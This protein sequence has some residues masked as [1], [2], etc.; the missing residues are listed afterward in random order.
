MF[1]IEVKNKA[2]GKVSTGGNTEIYI[3]GRKAE[4]VKSFKYEVSAKGVGVATV[5][6]YAD[7]HLESNVPEIIA[8]GIMLSDDNTH[9]IGKFVPVG[10]EDLEEEI[11]NERK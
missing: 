10:Y 3:D 5:E 9:Q 11:E 6:Y 2:P 7:L 8:E 4:Y 1:K